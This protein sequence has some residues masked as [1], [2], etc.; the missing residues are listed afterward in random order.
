MAIG[1]TVINGYVARDCFNLLY[2]YRDKEDIEHFLS[3]LFWNLLEYGEGEPVVFILTNDNAVKELQANLSGKVETF[4]NMVGLP[5]SETYNLDNR[6]AV[7][8]CPHNLSQSNQIK[9]KK[10]LETKGFYLICDTSRWGLR[11]HD[12][13][14]ALEIGRRLMLKADIIY[15][16]VADG[17][18]C[19]VQQYLLNK[20]M[21]KKIKVVEVDWKEVMGDA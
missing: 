15:N 20:C 18:N 14:K 2:R 10:Y 3:K 8:L 7:A 16:I 21:P 13:L 17:F 5:Y 1:I 6:L 4:C 11:T 9:V 12:E 19:N